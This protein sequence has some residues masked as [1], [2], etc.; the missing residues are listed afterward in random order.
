MTE[1]PGAHRVGRATLAV[2][3]TYVAF[4][5]GAQFG[6]LEQVRAATGGDAAMTRI[7]LAAMG[8]AGIAASFAARAFAPASATRAVR[9]GLAA[10]ALVSAASP[11]ARTP[12]ALALAAAG[13]GA[14]LGWLTVS[15]AGSLGDLAPRGAAGRVAGWGTG[16]AYL[17][18]NLPPLFGGAPATRAL[19]GAALCAVAFAFPPQAPPEE[20]QGERERA[21]VWPPR[22]FAAALVAL[23]GL[24]LVDSAFFARIQATPALLAFTWG[25]AA[26]S[27][28]QGIVHLAA[29]AMAGMALDRGRFASLL[30]FA[31]ALFGLS[32]PAIAESAALPGGGGAGALGAV[33]YA[34]GI[35][36]Y[37]AVL[38][39]TPSRCAPG[40]RA[41]LS[42]AALLYGVAGWAGSAVGIG[43]AEHGS[44]AAAGR[45][46]VA[47]FAGAALLPIAER[48]RVRSLVTAGAAAGATLLVFLIDAARLPNAAS[49]PADPVAR[50]RE[51]YLAEGCQ[52]CHSQYVRQGTRD[53]LWW[54]PARPFDRSE[55]P[56]T[57]GN[58]RI[59]PDLANVGLRRSPTWNRIH[60]IDPRAVSPGSRMPSF[61]HLFA[62]ERGDALVVYLG[63][64]GRGAERER[65]AA[66]EV[67]EPAPVPGSGSA[68]R[69][70]ELYARLCTACH[71]ASGRG[72]GSAAQPFA[73]PTMDLTVS[74]LPLL[75]P[76]GAAPGSAA[77]AAGD[78]ALARAIRFGIAPG[79]MPG[80]EWLSEG[81][82][83]DLA[84][85]VRGL[86]ERAGAPS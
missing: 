13:F 2:A 31:G 36:I 4:L 62:D 32:L 69:G 42:R 3:A 27:L 10:T 17:V 59:G 45:L 43:A 79:L 56:P 29:A 7:V 40:R 16:A 1:R 38:V 68:V 21:N 33:G 51:V 63:S 57:P 86:G 72:D 37:S 15:L 14:A 53:E 80:H 44:L 66:I 26:L 30:L 55:R 78:A 64:L 47:A 70:S 39:A 12:P 46:G 18:S 52:Y 84:A 22:L 28:R 41:A 49:S 65:D 5:L 83:A 54:G 82:V 48:L 35:A 74:T 11:L 76:P 20:E 77:R 6:F 58:R 8:I 61:A 25:G 34:A 24:V 50:G 81:E 23:A 60:L 9:L 85:F 73:R 19:A 71:G 67:S 75:D